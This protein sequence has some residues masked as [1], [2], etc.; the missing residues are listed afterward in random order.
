LLL[1]DWTEFGPDHGSVRVGTIADFL[2]D[3]CDLVG[4][5]LIGLGNSG[6]DK[7]ET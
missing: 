7:F 5:F 3:C 2:D 6:S 1:L 4:K